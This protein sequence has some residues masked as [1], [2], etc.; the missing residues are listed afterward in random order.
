MVRVV[1]QVASDVR[2]VADVRSALAE[3][4]NAT[5]VIPSPLPTRSCPKLP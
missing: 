3:L 4:T 1:V 5:K 2:V